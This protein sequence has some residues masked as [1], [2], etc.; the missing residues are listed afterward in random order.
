MHKVILLVSEK[1]SCNVY[2]CDYEE[3]LETQELGVKQV[4]G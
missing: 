4:A 3:V 2:L 1:E